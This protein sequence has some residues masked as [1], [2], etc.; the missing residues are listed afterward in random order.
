MTTTLTK[1]AKADKLYRDCEHCG[2]AYIP[3]KSR[4]RRAR[5]CSMD[6]FIAEGGRADMSPRPCMQCGKVFTPIYFHGVF[7]STNCARIGDYRPESVAKRAWRDV[8]KDEGTGC[9]VWHGRYTGA[10]Q[11]GIVVVG[12]HEDGKLKKTV[13]HRFFYEMLIGPIS[14]DLVLDH[15]CRNTSCVNPAHLEPVTNRENLDRGVSPC[16][17]KFFTHCKHGH[18]FTRENTYRRK[19]GSRKCRTCHLALMKCRR[20]VGLIPR[21]K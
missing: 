18:E 5:Y 6:C 14:E 15:L 7:C 11:Y 19:D 21:G 4:D 1:T 3:R 8:Q 13:A 12:R 2:K 20:A 9:W 16:G 17:K 10:A